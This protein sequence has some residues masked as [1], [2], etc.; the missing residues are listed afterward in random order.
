MSVLN[1]KMPIKTYPLLNDGM[2][3]ILEG[4]NYGIK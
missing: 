3:I 1:V 2:I 4:G